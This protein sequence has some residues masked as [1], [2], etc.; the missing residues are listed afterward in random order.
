MKRHVREMIRAI[1]SNGGKDLSIF[2]NSHTKI[3]WYDDQG[4]K[5]TLVMSTSPSDRHAIHNM[6]RDLA[7]LLSR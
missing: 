4:H 6:R 2:H 1:E 3:R 5:R 7:R